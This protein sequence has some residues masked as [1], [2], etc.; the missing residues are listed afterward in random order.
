MHQ[1][2]ESSEENIYDSFLE[3]LDENNEVKLVHFH[4]KNHNEDFLEKLNDA[5]MN[6]KLSDIFLK[7]YNDL[8]LKENLQESRFNK[9]YVDQT[10]K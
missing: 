9:A 3:Y 5:E 8:L 2:S 10:K 1:K 4:I 6:V 7:K